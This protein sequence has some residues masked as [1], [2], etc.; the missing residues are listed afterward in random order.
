MILN[1]DSYANWSRLTISA[2]KSKNKLDFFDGRI[3]K[4]Q[5]ISSPKAYT[6]ERSNSVV[7]AWLYNIIDK[8]LH[9]SVAYA[10]MA[11]QIW[12]NLEERYSQGHVIRVHQ[13]KREL[14]LTTQGKLSVAECFTNLN[15]LW[16]ELRNYQ[17]IHNCTCGAGK[18]MSKHLE[19][20]KIHQFLMGLDSDL[21][22]DRPLECSFT[23]TTAQLKQG[24][25]FYC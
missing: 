7:I 19:E 4:P 9:G 16:D 11:R 14:S 5:D 10:E 25:C 22:G 17:T 15:T 21:Y 3:T 6:W 13:I 8:N 23:R 2:L 18:H 12:T 24:V 20:E 1:G